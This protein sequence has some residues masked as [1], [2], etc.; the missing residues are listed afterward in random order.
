MSVGNSVSNLGS[1]AARR[2]ADLF[3]V[4][5]AVAALF[6]ESHPV[7]DEHGENMQ[8]DLIDEARLQALPGDVRPG[9]SKILSVGCREGPVDG[10]G[11]MGVEKGD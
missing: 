1:A 3:D 4:D 10:I 6:E 11:D 5:V 8:E 9:N 7:A 2:A